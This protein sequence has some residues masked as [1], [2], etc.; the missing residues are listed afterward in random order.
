MNQTNEDQNSIVI[1]KKSTE[2]ENCKK[3]GASLLLKG[4]SYESTKN[5][6]YTFIT[7]P[8]HNTKGGAVHKL[9]VNFTEN[10]IITR[11]KITAPSLGAIAAGGYATTWIRWKCDDSAG[12]LHLSAL[13]YFMSI[14]YGY[15][16]EIDFH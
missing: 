10:K 7:A 3:F 16:Y 12:S 13:K 8:M 2:A 4:Y 15:I 5:K 6:S 14:F 1:F 9:C 11:P